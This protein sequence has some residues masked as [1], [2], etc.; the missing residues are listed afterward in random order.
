MSVKTSVKEML[1]HL[2]CVYVCMLYVVLSGMM[3]DEKQI[4][5]SFISREIGKNIF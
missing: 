1:P 3:H 2:K 4:D 5:T